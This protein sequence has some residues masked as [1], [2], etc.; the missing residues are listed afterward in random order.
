MN[1]TNSFLPWAFCSSVGSAGAFTA[2]LLSRSITSLAFVFYIIPYRKTRLNKIEHEIF[3][4]KQPGPATLGSAALFLFRAVYDGLGEIPIFNV[5]FGVAGVY[6]CDLNLAA[7]VGIII[8]CRDVFEALLTTREAIC[9]CDDNEVVSLSGGLIK[10][11]L[12][13]ADHL[14]LLFAIVIRSAGHS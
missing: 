9:P 11:R 2:S 8:V 7:V 10:Q 4:K 14:N 3:T 13:P 6:A 12:S 1:F 5:E